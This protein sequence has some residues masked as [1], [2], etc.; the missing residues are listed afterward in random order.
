MI[1][2]KYSDFSK[3]KEY[4]LKNP[5]KLNEATDEEKNL[6]RQAAKEDVDNCVAQM[7]GKYKFFGEFLYKMRFLFDPPGVDTMATDG[8]NIFISSEFVNRLS[9]KQIKFVLAH[10]ILHVVLLHRGREEDYFGAVSYKTHGRWNV[11]AD[12]EINPLL[13]GEDILTEDELKEITDCI[14]MDW[15]GMPAEDIYPLLGN[16]GEDPKNPGQEYLPAEVGDII[17]TKDKKFG[18]ITEI[19]ADGKHVI[20]EITEEMATAAL[21][22]S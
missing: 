1:V 15:A 19:K 21:S 17:R 14:N 4:L 2:L 10:E 18:V 7:M 6:L 12:F 5:S 13:L 8:Q 11:A 9:Y 3:Y 22:G 16:K 20:K